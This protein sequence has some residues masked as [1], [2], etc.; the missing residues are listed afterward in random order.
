MNRVAMQ[1]RVVCALVVAILLSASTARAVVQELPRRQAIGDT[2]AVLRHLFKFQM[3]YENNLKMVRYNI[4]MTIAQIN[5]IDALILAET[6]LPAVDITR[7]TGFN[8]TYQELIDQIKQFGPTHYA[9]YLKQSKVAMEAAL[10]YAQAQRVAIAKNSNAEAL[11]DYDRVMNNIQTEIATIQA[12]I[13]R[14]G[15][16]AQAIDY[17]VLYEKRLDVLQKTM[18]DYEGILSAR[19]TEYKALFGMDAPVNTDYKSDTERLTSKDAETGLLVV[20]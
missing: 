7:F 8:K 19:R 18:R 5:T 2:V 15:E 4:N 17:E 16:M 20:D 10:K 14:V 13:D 9:K 6:R 3:E 1:N 11:K 12:R